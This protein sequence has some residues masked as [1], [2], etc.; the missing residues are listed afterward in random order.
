MTR[1]ELRQSYR[2]LMVSSR[3]LALVKTRGCVNI[4]VAE[5]EARGRGGGWG[6]I[7]KREKRR[8]GIEQDRITYI[9]KC[10]PWEQKQIICIEVLV[11]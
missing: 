9:S 2:S 10:Q 6:R 7:E 1:G 11:F 3:P 8:R 5:A 4:L